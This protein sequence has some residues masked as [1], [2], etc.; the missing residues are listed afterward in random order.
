MLKRLKTITL[1]ALA[2]AVG[3][4][5]GAVDAV[6]GIDWWF[7]I[8]DG[9]AIV[10][11]T[12]S[13]QDSAIDPTTPG[14]IEV[15]SELGGYPVTAIGPKAF[16]R[17]RNLTSVS[18]PA[19]V[20]RID[21]SAFYGCSS[22]ESVSLPDG[23]TALGNSAFYSCGKLRECEL[24]AS[25][26]T[27]GNS[28]FESCSSMSNVVFSGAIES[29]GSSAF[30]SCGQLA[31]VNIP[32][33]V[34]SVGGS[35]FYNCSSLTNVC[36]AANVGSV[37]SLAFEGC[38]SLKD[39]RFAAKVGSVEASVFFGCTALADI[40]FEG[41]VGSIGETAFYKCSAL[42]NVTF[43]ATLTNIQSYAFSNCASLPG[44]VLPSSVSNIAEGAFYNCRAFTAFEFP[45]GVKVAS[46]AVLAGCSNLVEIVIPEGVTSIGNGAFLNCSKLAD[47]NLPKGIL[48]IEK[49]AFE[50]TAFWKE[51][52]DDSIVI[53][54]NYIVGIKGECPSK[55]VIS[56]GV[57][58]ISAN[59]FRDCTNLVEVV[60]PESLKAIGPY[61][62]YNTGL[63]EVMFPSGLEIVGERAFAESKGL[64]RVSKVSG[65]RCGEGA[66]EHTGLPTVSV[67]F[68]ANR[69]WLDASE[70]NKSFAVGVP[71]GAMP[72]PTRSSAY[73]YQFAGWHTAAKGGALVAE[74]NIVSDTLTMLYAHWR[75][76]YPFTYSV[77]FYADS[78]ATGYYYLQ[79]LTN[80]VVQVLRTNDFCSKPGYLF[81]G[82]TTV[83]GGPVV[84]SD[85]DTIAEGLTTEA[86]ESVPLYACWVDNAYDVMGS[87]K[88]F[89]TVSSFPVSWTGRL[90]WDTLQSGD[91]RQTIS[92]KVG[93]SRKADI[94]ARGLEG[95]SI[96]TIELWRK[97]SSATS[98]WERVCSVYSSAAASCDFT[99]DVQYQLRL[100]SSTLTKGSLVYSIGI[101]TAVNI[102]FD[103]D[104]GSGGGAWPYIAN[105][106]Y[107]TLP[108][109][110]KNECDFEGWYNVKGS[111][112]VKEDTM[113][114]PSVTNL[115]AHWAM[116]HVYYVTFNSNGG[117]GMMEQIAHRYGET[118]FLP[119]NTFV[120]D[121]YR[122]D[123][124]AV[125]ADGPVKYADGAKVSNL[126]QQSGGKL[127]LYA[128]WSRIREAVNYPIATD[129]VTNDIGA[130]SVISNSLIFT[131]TLT[132]A[133]NRH[134]L[135]FTAADSDVCRLAVDP[136]AGLR[137]GAKL[138]YGSVLVT[139]LAKT[140]Q[141][142]TFERDDVV[143]LVV[144]CDLQ[145]AETYEYEVSVGAVGRLV[146]YDLNDGVFVGED[147]SRG[148]N[149]NFTVGTPVGYLPTPTN[150]EDA[151]FFLGWYDAATNL[152]DAAMLVPQNGLV[153]A[154]KWTDP[155]PYQYRIRFEANG[156]EGVMPEVTFWSTNSVSLPSNAF[157]RAGCTFKGW[158]RSPN[159]D[160]EYGD[161]ATIAKPLAKKKDSQTPVVLYARWSGEGGV[162]IDLVG[163]IF[164]H[165]KVIGGGAEICNKLSG[166]DVAAIDVATAGDVA[167]PLELGG[168]PV[169][170]IGSRAF[171]GCNKLT[172]IVLPKDVESIE[173]FAFENCTNLTAVKFMG[174][175]PSANPNIYAGTSRDLVSKV[176][177]DCRETWLSEDGKTLQQLWPVPDEAVGGEY[178]HSRRVSWWTDAPKDDP[179]ATITFYYYDTTG[180]VLKMSPEEGLGVVPDRE[181]YDFAG[182]WTKPYGGVEVTE[183]N[184]K[185]LGVTKVYAHWT[186]NRDDYDDPEVWDGG[187]YD[188][189]RAHVYD[190]Y[191]TD[192]A[193]VA[194]TIQVK[195]A[196]GKTSKKTEET[197]VSLTAKVLILGEGK[198]IS[199]KGT[200]EDVDE[201]GGSCDLACST[202]SDKRVLSVSFEGGELEG[203]LDGY[204]VVA[205]RSPFSGT[206]D[207]D[208]RTALAA[209]DDWGSPRVV[210]LRASGDS[211]MAN[212]YAT[213]SVKPGTKGKVRVSGML[214]DGAKVST[215][216]QMMLGEDSCEI[217]VVAPLYTKKAGGFAFLIQ[218][219]REDDPAVTG[220]SD[221]I[222]NPGK[223]G[224]FTA[225]LEPVGGEGDAGIGRGGR[226]LSDSLFSLEEDFDAE[227]VDIETDLLPNGLPISVAG[228]KWTLPKGDENPSELKLTYSTDGTF[229]GSFKVYAITDTGKSKKYTANVTGV[230]LDGV[231]YGTATIKKVGSAPVIIEAK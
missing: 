74:T 223:E 98:A 161:C 208:R 153:L 58:T 124:W 30:S 221:W 229:K 204:D 117:Q 31:S 201:S 194:G 141:E 77:C 182:W 130:V 230:V 179:G 55:V 40:R 9:H 125:S 20:T 197:T 3:R 168:V 133:T 50:G 205:V 18:I 103:P 217:P 231:G 72:V 198:S 91:R 27:V 87:G 69:G 136:S 167:V 51:Q 142:L 185:E 17:C 132:A 32:Q 138:S 85:G 189:D 5:F 213:L 166:K 158:A 224:E 23:V 162:E 6:D 101:G 111:A 149:F 150:L 79:T 78:E 164:W 49:R 169:V 13:T 66:F 226:L 99:K 174:P 41:D 70:T 156:A 115:I 10:Q 48:T 15:P 83:K 80:G 52:P 92:F 192:G 107:G 203:S 134:Y 116:R 44:V 56:N 177:P 82:W 25:V 46:D 7:K 39:V 210:V 73:N 186:R 212:G 215:S 21:Y 191:L 12:M 196:K 26:R 68:D 220:L 37:G 178:R 127:E 102:Y 42:T 90:D 33:P 218:L 219:S 121:H 86:Y 129:S 43:G 4:S 187:S 28:A 94:V 29:I 170:G 96:P 206:S 16:Y 144:E 122:F 64:T 181:G 151:V 119:A 202:K 175:Q 93:S 112:L 100:T 34:E 19:G 45:A 225:S 76:D 59:M 172:S 106:P 183:Y 128:V 209:K 195:A 108:T 84:Y 145:G 22:L 180:T 200:A 165:Y 63:R 131:G 154:A 152:Y 36:F 95:S 11:S 57:E 47:V 211:P 171:S 227:D 135:V 67:G 62:F 8:E 88:D 65:F 60:F 2:L 14:P 216:A 61:A 75:T 163:G 105:L 35:A 1:T 157:V 207:E 146:S 148:T 53:L 139:D 193:T 190:G 176:N 228:S 173:D 140:S 114:S 109:T 24:P 159:G 120:R 126:V 160:V 38:L 71:Y 118:F 143:C 184:Y 137:R 113:V 214:P 188:T 110:T 147:A 199:F 89:G 222:G 123:G 81:A 97:L 155:P 54:D 104:G